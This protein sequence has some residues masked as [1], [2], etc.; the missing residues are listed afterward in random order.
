M[1]IVRLTKVF[2]DY[3]KKISFM[4]IEQK[5]KTIVLGLNT[6]L[7]NFKFGKVSKM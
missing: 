5:L 4:K 7:V 1:L 6:F 3:R 2:I